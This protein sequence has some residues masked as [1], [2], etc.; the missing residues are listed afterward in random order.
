MSALVS[1]PMR[2]PRLYLETRDG[3][4]EPVG[5]RG[6][7][8]WVVARELCR[9]VQV[10]LLA[11][12]TA[13]QQLDALAL[14]IERQSPFRETGHHFHL[15]TNL[16]SL[17]LWDQG[18][19]LAAAAQV[20]VELERVRMVPETALLPKGTTGARLVET[21][22]GVEGQS[23]MNGDLAA[24]RWWPAVPDERSWIMFQRGAS[25]PPEEIR[26]SVPAPL[27]L[28]WLERPWTRMPSLGARG[29]AGIDMRLVAAAAGVLIVA[30]YGYL[31]AEWLRIELDSRTAH[32]E[33]VSLLKRADPIIDARSTALAN[34]AV[35]AKLRKLDPLPGQ[36]A[37]MAHVAEVIPRGEAFFTDWTFD[38]G[39]LQVTIASRRRL[40]AVYY[41]KSLEAVKGF[42]NVSAERAGSDFVLRVHLT[43]APK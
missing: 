11:E 21:L 3:V 18:V 9:F 40:D 32:T 6:P 1:W 25:L 16:I 5:G 24:S 22:T 30:I 43:V 10:P 20:G 15:G 29:L 17:W 39:Q 41:V 36:L 2:A 7:R 34:E 42:T 35:I 23:W 14:Q 26:P 8:Y 27:R 33:N 37:I 12:A 31:G 13:R 38:R 4:R 19:A 28:D